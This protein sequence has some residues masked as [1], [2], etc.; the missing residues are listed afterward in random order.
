M[1]VVLWVAESRVFSQK[2]SFAVY[3]SPQCS[4]CADFTLV[5][6]WQ[7]LTL[8]DRCG[9]VWPDFLFCTLHVHNQATESPEMPPD[10]V[11]G[12]PPLCQV[13]GQRVQHRTV[14][15]QELAEPPTPQRQ[16]LS[17]RT[18]RKGHFPASAC[19]TLGPSDHLGVTQFLRC[20]STVVLTKS[21]M[22]A[23]VC[24]H[25]YAYMLKVS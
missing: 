4:Q 16:D 20:T 8:G 13:L 5:I 2:T 6:H 21:K 23:H 12:F 10:S 9:K 25:T 24:A 22:H 11:P 19:D 17:R 7:L 15:A 3:L 14:T 18:L 1:W